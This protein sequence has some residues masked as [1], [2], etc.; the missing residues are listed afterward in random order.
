MSEAKAGFVATARKYRPQKFIE[1]LA[2]PGVTVTLQNALARA[3]VHHAYLFCGPR[4][5]GKTTTARVLAKALNCINRTAGEPCGQCDPCKAF[6]QGR[7][8]DIIEIDGASNRGVDDIR[9][10]RERVAYAAAGGGYKVYIVDEVHMLTNEAFNAL[11]KTLEEPPPKVAFIFATTEPGKVP[12]TI[13]SRCQRF[14]FR[15]IAVEPLHEALTRVTQAESI[16]VDSDALELLARRA[17]GSLRDAF[18]LL[19]QTSAF[20]DG[21]ITRETVEQALGIIPEESLFEITALWAERSTAKAFEHLDRLWEAGVDPVEWAQAF[22]EQLRSLLAANVGG[23]ASTG[24]RFEQAAAPFQ[25]G[26]ILRAQVMLSDLKLRLRLLTDPR[27]EV[28]LFVLRLFT[29]ADTVRLSEFVSGSTARAAQSPARPNPETQAAAAPPAG[30]TLDLKGTSHDER[31]LPAEPFDRF[32]LI[33]RKKAPW[34]AAELRKGALEE[35]TNLR[36]RFFVPESNPFNQSRFN[37]NG[38]RAAVADAFHA[39]WGARPQIEF[40][41]GDTVN[42]APD[43]KTLLENNPDLAALIAAT[44]GEILARRPRNHEG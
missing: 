31:D 42:N 40:R 8:L 35:N 39:V 26:D 23:E 16:D 27:P 21:K 33:L 9:N 34:A 19:D 24:T 43:T 22:G 13:L 1:I 32:L 18:S 25:L 29:L 28:E 3:R 2:Q 15:R 4:G 7:T 44:D 36:A 41:F 12:P 30:S 20:A 14:D 38:I 10:L 17:S 11:L 37:T 6:E 5:T